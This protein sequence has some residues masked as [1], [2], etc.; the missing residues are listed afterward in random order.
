MAVYAKNDDKILMIIRLTEPF[1]GKYAFPGG[2]LAVDK[3]DVYDTAARELKEETG[4]SIDK[5]DLILIDVRSNPKRDPRDHVL[6]IGF[7]AI[8]ENSS[9]IA[10]ITDE[11][12]S[13]WI[14]LADLDRLEFA[15]DHDIYAANIKSYLEKI[16]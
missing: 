10:P 1:K 16:K 15:F 9:A 11:A 14:S 5:K 6:D 3:E 7:L 4:F 2:F 12:K 8:I 13:F